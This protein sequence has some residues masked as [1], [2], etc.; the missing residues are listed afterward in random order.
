MNFFWRGFEKRAALRETTTLEPQQ[1]RV[2][3]R[4]QKS[5]G[6]LV[7]HGLGSGKTLTALGATQD[8]PTDVVVPAALRQN[9]AK[10]VQKH[11][12]GH[13]PKIMS[14][15]QAVKSEPTGKNLVV[16][17]AHMLGIPDSKRSQ[18]L[19][20]KA[21]DYEKRILLTGTPI[22][23][24]PHEVAPL[25]AMVRGDTKVPVDRE[26]FNKAYVQEAQTNPGLFAKL[27][28]GATPGTEYKIKNPEHFAK[29]VQGFVDYHAPDK[30][31]FPSVTR[32]TIQVPMDEEQKKY[33]D[34]VLDKAGPAMSYKIRRGLP[35]SK[36]EAKSLNSFLSGARQVSNSTRAFG[37]EK[38]SPKIQRA[39]QE[40]TTRMEKDP[41][42]RAMVYSNYLGSGVNDYASQ[43]KSR[44]IPHTLFTGELS[45][46]ERKK[47]VEDYNAGLT[48]A[49]L[50]SGAGAQGLDLKGTKLVQLLEPH[51]NTARLEQAEGRGI[52]YKSHEHLPE[53]ER[54]VHVQKFQSTVPRTFFQK[55]L[56][57]KPDQ[58]VD[59]YLDMLSARKDALNEQFL[60]ILRQKGSEK[61]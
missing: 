36:A 48:R 5:P 27:L 43:L 59:E 39:V 4:L 52:R 12:T 17:E 35:P 55:V 21:R 7:Y 37:G 45:D 22:R 24:Y 2:Q 34:F 15:E 50:I 18:N 1:I 44:G 10:E 8:G 13:K 32:E 9:Y 56:R 46:K 28:H 47:A 42:F 23:N 3:Q 30:K 20:R 33:Y 14:Y 31:N 58:G 54:N 25:L 49:L 53:N 29:M 6:V 41:N 11:T 38:V 61:V 26:A 40:L 57:Q 19:V 51:W 16:D 60:D